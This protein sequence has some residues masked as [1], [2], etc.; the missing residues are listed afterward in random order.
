MFSQPRDREETYRTVKYAVS[1][2]ATLF[3][4][5]LQ[6]ARIQGLEQLKTAEKLPRDRHDGSPVI[7]LSAVLK[8]IV[9]IDGK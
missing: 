4:M 1:L 8:Q 3:D 9:S 2:V 6:R 5:I 7:K